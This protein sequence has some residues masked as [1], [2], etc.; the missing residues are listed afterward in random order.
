MSDRRWCFVG[1]G[2]IAVGL[3]NFWLVWIESRDTLGE[4]IQVLIFEV[5]N[6]GSSVADGLDHLN[7]FVGRYFSGD[8][9]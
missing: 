4:P 2:V 1:G 8:V 9:S 3:G 6:A 5:P 7:G